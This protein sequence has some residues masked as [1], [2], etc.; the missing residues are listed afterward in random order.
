MNSNVGQSSGFS[1]SGNDLQNG[2]SSS[3]GNDGQRGGP[4]FEMDDSLDFLESMDFL[5]SAAPTFPSLFSPAQHFDTGVQGE[6]SN[7]PETEEIHNTDGKEEAE[8]DEPRL[9]N[10]DGEGEGELNA[11]D[12]SFAVGEE[13]EVDYKGKGKW[14]IG[15]LTRINADGT[16]EVKYDDNSKEKGIVQSCVRPHLG[17]ESPGGRHQNPPSKKA[18][19]VDDSIQKAGK[20]TAAAAMHQRI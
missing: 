4:S 1:S 13:V 16:F 5:E 8:F 14:W 11:R 12:P 17:I 10:I 20:G 2:S 3:D 7:P 6:S 9:R 19:R 18:R 15:R